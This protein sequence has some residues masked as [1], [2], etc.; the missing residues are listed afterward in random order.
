MHVLAELVI[1]FARG[2]KAVDSMVPV[3]SNV[4]DDLPQPT[5]L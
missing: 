5:D 1:D 2:I 4:L 3:A